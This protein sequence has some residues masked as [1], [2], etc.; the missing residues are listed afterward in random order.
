VILVYDIIVPGSGT[1][2][3][4]G[5]TKGTAPGGAP[6]TDGTDGSAGKVVYLA[7]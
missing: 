2:E 3:A 4:A 5:G 7:M 6:A 1:I